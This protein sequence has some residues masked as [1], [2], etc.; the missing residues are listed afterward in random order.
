MRSLPILTLTLALCALSMIDNGKPPKIPLFQ[1]KE[2]VSI[3]CEYRP[4]GEV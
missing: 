3:S 1:H 4:D 2:V